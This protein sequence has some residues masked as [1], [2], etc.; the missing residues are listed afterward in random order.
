MKEKSSGGVFAK[1]KRFFFH[2]ATITVFGLLSIAFFYLVGYSLVRPAIIKYFPAA[3]YGD[4]FNSLRSQMEKDATT[5]VNEDFFEGFTGKEYYQG[6]WAV[7]E[8][9]VKIYV[10]HKAEYK[11]A[12]LFDISYKY[13]EFVAHT[14]I[15][16]ITSSNTL[17][18]TEE[19]IPFMLRTD[20][21]DQDGSPYK[22]EI[23]FDD[24]TIYT[25]NVSLHQN[26]ALHADLTLG[27]VFYENIP[28]S[29]LGWD[30]KKVI[31]A[32]DSIID[33]SLKSLVCFKQLLLNHGIENY[34][35]MG[36][37]IAYIF[38]RNLQET[39]LPVLL[40]LASI[41]GIP[42]LT[43]F[44]IGALGK[45][46]ERKEELYRKVLS[47]DDLPP[48]MAPPKKKSKF[49]LSLARKA[50]QFDSVISRSNLRPVFGE[51]F[52]RTVGLVFM[53]IANI[54]AYLITAASS[55]VWGVGWQNFATYSAG[56]IDAI[57]EIGQFVLVYAVIVI[58][59]ETH[60]NL[61]ISAIFFAT[62]SVGYYFVVSGIM[63]FIEIAF[64]INNDQITA[65]LTSFLPGNLFMGIGIFA[66]IGVF[67]FGDV[68]IWFRNRRS[69]YRALSILPTLIAIA[70]IAGTILVRAGFLLRSYWIINL[71]FI[72]DFEVIFIGIVYLYIIFAFRTFLRKKYGFEQA[73]K[74]MQERT[75]IFEKNIILCT[76]VLFYVALFYLM[77]SGLR[78]DLGMIRNHTFIWI[79]I[80]FFLFNKPAAED[81]KV[82]SDGIYY[83]LYF[84]IL[85]AP[86]G[87]DFIINIYTS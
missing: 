1:I 55:G 31:R 57:Y 38:N 12:I 27:E 32:K 7:D 61:H 80:P 22:G 84:L 72:R 17:L 20:I 16:T 64:K 24:G 30:D 48:E 25:Y 42:I 2:D 33:A 13:D 51:W 23:T 83:V 52:F 26:F 18:L 36:S 14:R 69:L 71:L 49:S 10:S 87:L 73:E 62:L 5:L 4:A 76:L 40:S 79:M 6:T 67:L 44:L 19:G 68:P 41:E 75:I 35:E 85:L 45:H 28:Q 77:P 34:E 58:I 43:I 8:Q 78:K 86:R 11:D 37:R 70:S 39:M 65:A 47:N 3:D 81:H 9:E 56:W 74:K 66:M 60:K 82:L 53:L 15:R 29:T 21:L 59:S 54:G 50:K 63:Y 46:S